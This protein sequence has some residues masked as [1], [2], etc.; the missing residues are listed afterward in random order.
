MPIGFRSN[1]SR[2]PARPPPSFLSFDRYKSKAGASENQA[3]GEK[4]RESSEAEVEGKVLAW[5]GG[6]DKRRVSAAAASTFLVRDLISTPCEDM[7]PQHLE[8]TVE[9]ERGGGAL[10]DSVGWFFGWLIDFVVVFLFVCSVGRLPRLVCFWL[11]LSLSPCVLHALPILF[12]FLLAF[13]NS[14]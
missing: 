8:V 9:M 14:D 2:P 4:S 7:G 12:F 10:V 11:V 6:A 5:P 3:E 13:L 1:S